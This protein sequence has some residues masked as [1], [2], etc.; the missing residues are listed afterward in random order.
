MLAMITFSMFSMVNGEKKKTKP[1]QTKPNQT[2]QN[3]Y[4]KN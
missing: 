4:L 1:N 3:S 2:K